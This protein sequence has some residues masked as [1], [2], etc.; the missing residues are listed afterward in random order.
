MDQR[1]EG[2]RE[3]FRERER[4]REGEI[5]GGKGKDK[6]L[7]TEKRHRVLG[8]GSVATLFTTPM[9]FVRTMNS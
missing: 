9:R 5:K 6:D 4:G 3:G 8:H 2:E 1:W 7:E